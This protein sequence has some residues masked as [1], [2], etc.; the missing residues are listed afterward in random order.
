L[1][2]KDCGN[3]LEHF[4][5]LDMLDKAL[6]V[7]AAFVIERSLEGIDASHEPAKV[8]DNEMFAQAKL[9]MVRYHLQYLAFHL[10]RTHVESRTFK[11]PKIKKHML[12][13]AKIYAVD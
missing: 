11:D 5:K 6:Q 3:N 12:L 10:F 9:V 13:L 7:R 2:L 1:A 4:M 8:K